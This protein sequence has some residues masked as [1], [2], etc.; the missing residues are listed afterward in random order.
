[1]SQTGVTHSKIRP[2]APADGAEIERC[3]RTV[4]ERIDEGNLED[5]TG[6]NAVIAEITVTHNHVRLHSALSFLCQVDYYRRNPE[7]LPA[8][9][10][11][12]SRAARELREQENVKLR[13][14]LNPW[15]DEQTS[16]YRK[17]VVVSL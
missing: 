11:R 10:R 5:R 1:L 3:H 15:K 4:A 14:R 7:A 17:A 13:Q 8:E 9:R 12:K 6:A 16:P 2:H